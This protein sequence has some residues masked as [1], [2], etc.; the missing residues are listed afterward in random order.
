MAS[1]KISNLFCSMI[2]PAEKRK[3]APN[4]MNGYIYNIYDIP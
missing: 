2:F 3:K 4:E 1:W